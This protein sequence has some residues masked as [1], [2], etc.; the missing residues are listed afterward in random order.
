[1]T[2]TSSGQCNITTPWVKP[3][4][5]VC[6]ALGPLLHHWI[7]GLA[8]ALC[9]CGAGLPWSF[10]AGWAGCPRHKQGGWHL[11][12]PTRRREHL[13]RA[14]LFGP[15]AFHPCSF[16]L[17]LTA[18]CPPVLSDPPPPPLPWLGLPCLLVE[19][20]LTERYVP[21]FCRHLSFSTSESWIPPWHA[22]HYDRDL[23][24]LGTYTRPPTTALH[25]LVAV[26]C[27]MGKRHHQTPSRPHKGGDGVG[28]AAQPDPLHCPPSLPNAKFCLSVASLHLVLQ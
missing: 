19:G 10:T 7:P 24:I 28:L 6:V 15:K 1:M 4:Y 17:S 14:V 11:Q 21:A 8:V 16:F 13:G 25:Y 3:Q 18:R 26:H 20:A 2:G 9:P 23:T 5:M 22:V 12:T 27:A